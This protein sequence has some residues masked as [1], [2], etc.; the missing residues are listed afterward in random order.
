MNAYEL[1]K[2]VQAWKVERV[3]VMPTTEQCEMKFPD[4]DVIQLQKLYADIGW[5]HPQNSWIESKVKWA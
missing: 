5:R 4:V 1:T 3:G 2:A